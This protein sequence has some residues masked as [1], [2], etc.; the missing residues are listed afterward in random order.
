MK[1]IL[2]IIISFLMSCSKQ[3]INPSN[4]IIGSWRIYAG[5]ITNC[6]NLSDNQ[7]ESPISVNQI[8][9]FTKD[10]FELVGDK[11]YLK[12]K[13]IIK[14]DSILMPSLKPFGLDKLKFSIS[15]SKIDLNY[16]S[17]KGCITHN[18]YSKQ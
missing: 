17:S 5:S 15:G 3:D 2:I 7:N 9:A 10:S 11:Y 18:F 6:Q 12:G 1:T 16:I 4:S 14:K 13:Y 8:Y